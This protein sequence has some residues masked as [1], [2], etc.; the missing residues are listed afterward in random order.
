MSETPSQERDVARRFAE[1]FSA[2]D[3]YGVIA[4]LSGDAWLTMPPAP[5]DNHGAGRSRLR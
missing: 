5:H 3:I 2:E 1:A 4:L